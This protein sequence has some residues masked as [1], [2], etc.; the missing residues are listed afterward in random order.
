MEQQ[1]TGKQFPGE[2]VSR[3]TLVLL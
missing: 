1:A 3:K 2:N